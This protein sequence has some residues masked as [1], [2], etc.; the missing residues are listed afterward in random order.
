MTYIINIRKSTFYALLW[1]N[2]S[3][4]YSIYIFI[5][6]IKKL[7]PFSH[8]NVTVVQLYSIW[9]T[10]STEWKFSEIRCCFIQLRSQQLYSCKNW[11]FVF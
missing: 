2:D 9:I 1:L 7:K 10:F 8:I 11:S 4:K 6:K 3:I 5:E